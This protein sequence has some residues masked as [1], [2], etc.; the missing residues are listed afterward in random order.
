MRRHRHVNDTCELRQRLLH[1][2]RGMEQ[3]LIDDGV[4]Q[5]PTRLRDCV[6]ANDGHSEH[7]LWL[8][9]FF[10]LYLMNFMFHTTLDAVGS[11]SAL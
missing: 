7:N 6:R 2:W 8:S 3:S 5:W 9:S 10:P 1:V 11:K 4:G